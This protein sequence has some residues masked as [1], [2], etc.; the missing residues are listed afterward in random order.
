MPIHVIVA[1]RTCLHSDLS[2]LIISTTSLNHPVAIYS[3]LAIM[4][5]SMMPFVVLAT[6]GDVLSL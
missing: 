4:R 3:I 1:F 5:C 6:T 2:I